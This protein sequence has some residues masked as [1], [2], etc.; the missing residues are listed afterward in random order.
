[1]A[2]LLVLR[3]VRMMVALGTAAPLASKMVPENFAA[4]F[5]AGRRRAANGMSNSKTS[6]DAADLVRDDRE[7]RSSDGFNMAENL[8]SKWDKR[9]KASAEDQARLGL[10]SVAARW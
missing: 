9:A 6:R 3:S 10:V 5:C 1:M 2:T 4:A 7:R 8:L